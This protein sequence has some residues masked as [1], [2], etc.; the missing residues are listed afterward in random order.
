MRD[1]I[2]DVLKSWLYIED[3]QGIDCILAVVIAS[4]YSGDPLWMFIVDPPGAM[5]TE[6]CR[7]FSQSKHIYP[8]DTLTPESLI[9]GF[10]SRKGVRVDILEDIDGKLLVIKDFTAILQRPSAVREELFG[11]LRAVYDGELSMAYGSGVKKQTRIATFGILAAVTPMIDQ[12]TTVH[13]LLG[14]RFIRIRTHY[15]REQATRTALKQ[16]GKEKEMRAEINEVV[17]VALDY[18]HLTHKDPAPLLYSTENKIVALADITS[19]LRTPIMRNYR[20]EIVQMPEPEVGTRLA[21]QFARLGQ[22][23]HILD[24]YTYQHLTR[25]AKDTIPRVRLNMIKLFYNE[26]ELRTRQL[27]DTLNFPRHVVLHTAEDLWTLKAINR[28]L[29][30]VS[31][32]DVTDSTADGK[33]TYCYGLVKSFR[34]KLEVAGL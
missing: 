30:S 25:V 6:I 12:Y 31:S 20:N 34:D 8:I 21:K 7:S 15:N 13:S 4:M 9:S 29:E 32:E 28:R 14:E 18:Y 5:K 33:K 1:T 27:M 11:R 23:L 24:C 17:R 22:C 2:I 19:I 10:K 26:G 16:V 3:E